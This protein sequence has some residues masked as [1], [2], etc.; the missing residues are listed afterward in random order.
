MHS[1]KKVSTKKR[2]RS[3]KHAL[4]QERVHEKKI[5]KKIKKR[6]KLFILVGS[7]NYYKVVE[8][9]IDIS[10]YLK[11][12]FSL[13]RVLFCGRFLDQVRDFLF[14]YSLFFFYKFPVQV[15]RKHAHKE[16]ILIE[17]INTQN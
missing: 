1:T 17:F 8:S 3:R 2:T 15:R 10:L 6:F 14:S 13:V 12:S 4:V 16:I 7:T 9:K 5:F 11:I